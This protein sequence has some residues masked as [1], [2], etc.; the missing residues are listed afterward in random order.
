MGRRESFV[1]RFIS[2]IIGAF[3]AGLMAAAPAFPQNAKGRASNPP[4][5]DAPAKADTS[6]T[7]GSTQTPPGIRIQSNMVREPV[8]VTD[9]VTGEFVY[10]LEQKDFQIFDNGKPQRITGFAREPHEIAAVIVIQD[11]EAVGPLLKE[12]KMLGPIF[13]QL[14]LGPNGR[15]AVITFGS[16]INVAQGFSNSEA[17]L[18]K[19]L[20][21]LSTDGPKAR[22]ND[23]LV[24]AMN[25]LAHR[26]QGERRVI[27]VFSSGYDSGSETSSDEVIRRAAASEVEIYG[28]G[29]SLTKS[30]LSRDLQPMNAPTTPENSSVAIPPTPGTPST[31]SSSMQRSGVMVPATGAV[32][33]AVRGVESKFHANDV[34]SYARYTG[35]VFYGQWS[36]RAL[37]V[38]LS[39]IS[40]DIHSQYLL[41]YV[42]DDLSQ[43]GFHRLEVKVRKD[44]VNVRTRRGYFYEG[45]K[46]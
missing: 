11:N 18:D 31:P 17:D 9:K 12:L 27:I 21:A 43:R 41:A 19:T 42:P 40:A 10:D 33:A 16:T 7:A 13:S 4:A 44:G 45:P 20:E 28:I 34:E 2:L 39:E 5:A 1:Y 8:T 23:A 6:A 25:L 15:A 29:L 32:H 24:Q 22:L 46:Q 37:Q 38:H 35:G 26:P 3:V 30:Y 36:E 14:M